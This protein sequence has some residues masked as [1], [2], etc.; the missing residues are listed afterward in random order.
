MIK[1]TPNIA[2]YPR[3]FGGKILQARYHVVS[4]LSDAGQE[5]LLGNGVQ[6][7]L[8]QD[9]LAGLSH[10]GIEDPSVGKISV[11]AQSRKYSV[12][13]SPG[14]WEPSLSCGKYRQ[15]AFSWSRSRCRPRPPAGNARGTTSSL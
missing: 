9:E 12:L 1:I 4:N 14:V 7:G 10:P 11:R 3:I 2:K 5:I 8:Q 6:D 15:R 13:T